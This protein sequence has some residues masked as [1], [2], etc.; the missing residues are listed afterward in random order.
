MLLRHYISSS[1][2]AITR[3]VK[4]LPRPGS[5]FRPPN[6]AYLLYH[7]SVATDRGQ[8]VGCRVFMAEKR[9]SVPG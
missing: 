2:L 8:G 3:K 7:K 4:T 6:A 9:S 1:L 5:L